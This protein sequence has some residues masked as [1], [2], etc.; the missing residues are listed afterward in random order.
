MVLWTS[1]WNNI[2]IW[3]DEDTAT[4]SNMVRNFSRQNP[5]DII[6]SYR[7]IFTCHTKMN[8]LLQLKNRYS[9]DVFNSLVTDLQNANKSGIV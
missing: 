3:E 1:R 6:R 5:L 9:V 7:K 4:S 8:R 2:N